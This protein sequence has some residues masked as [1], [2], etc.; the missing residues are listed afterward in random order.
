M[1][2]SANIGEGEHEHEHEAK[3]QYRSFAS[4]KIEGRNLYS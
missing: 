2:G 4:S 3:I 1:V